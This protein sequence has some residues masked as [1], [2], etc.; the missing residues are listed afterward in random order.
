MILSLQHKNLRLE[1]DNMQKEKKIK[2]IEEK[3]A[4][5]NIM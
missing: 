5:G 2:K 3:Q 4:K 1:L